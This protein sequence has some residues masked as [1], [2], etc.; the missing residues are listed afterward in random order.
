MLRAERAC[1]GGARSARSPSCCGDVTRDP[2]MLLFLSL[3]D[4]DK[5]APNENYARELMELFTLG[6]GYSETDIRQAARALTGF[7]VEV[8][9]RRLPVAS[10]TTPSGTTPGSRRSSASAGAST[11]KDVLDLVLAHPAHAPFLVGKLWAYFVTEPPSRGDRARAWSRIYRAPG[12]QIKPVVRGDPRPPRRSTGTSTRPTWSSRPSSTSPA[13]LRTAGLAHRR[14]TRP[15]WLLDSDGPAAVPPAVGRRLGLGAG[16]DVVELDARALRLRQPR[17]LRRRRCSAP[18][19]GRS[20]R[21]PLAAEAFEQALDAVGA[22]LDL[23]R[24]PAARSS[25]GRPLLR[26]HSPRAA[27]ARPTARADMLQRAL[28]HLAARRPRRPAALTDAAL[29]PPRLRRLPPDHRGA[30]D[31]WLG[32]PLTRRQVLDRRRS[33]PASTIYAA[34]RRCRSRACSRRPS[35]EAPAAPDA[36]VLV[37]VFLPGG[38]DLL[39]TLPPM[40]RLRPLRRPAPG[41]SRCEAPPRARRDRPRRP[42]VARRR[43]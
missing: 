4:S 42:P 11:W 14:W 16:V 7:T 6:N 24:A 12:M 23:G 43:A 41:G 10:A 32:R 30:R 26:R 40:Q 19:R 27:A 20:A 21:R 5:E 36:P 29:R 33:A 22:P 8:D 3:A 15:T 1:S 25:H 38:C 9:R 17:S 13:T 2:A 35:A 28:R 37:S 18:R 31:R 34:T 39:D